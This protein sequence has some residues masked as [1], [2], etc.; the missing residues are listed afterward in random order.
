MGYDGFYWF[1]LGLY[2]N[3]LGFTGFC[4]VWMGYDGFYWDTL[5]SHQDLLGFTGFFY[6]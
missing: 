6:D 1:T 2:Q 5:G 4:W 3:L